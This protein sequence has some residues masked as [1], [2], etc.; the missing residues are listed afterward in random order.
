[1]KSN[2]FYIFEYNSKESVKKY[3]RILMM[4]FQIPLLLFILFMIF[5]P[6]V[7]DVLKKKPLPYNNPWLFL[8]IYPVLIGISGIIS[9]IVHELG[10]VF[11]GIITGKSFYD[12]TFLVFTIE[13]SK[14]T[15]KFHFYYDDSYLK[16]FVAVGKATMVDK[17]NKYNPFNNIIYYLGGA[18]F[19]ILAW[20]LLFIFQG[21]SILSLMML[22]SGLS[23]LIPFRYISTTGGFDGYLIIS[24]LFSPKAR[25]MYKMQHEV[26][27][28]LFA[29]VKLTADE[30][31]KISEYLIHSP[32]LNNQCLAYFLLAEFYL[33]NRCFEKATY[34][35]DEI[36]EMKK[37][38][39]KGEAFWYN[40]D[41]IKRLEDNILHDKSA[42]E[43]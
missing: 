12:M 25:E 19:N 11:F 31:F 16:D 24:T 3:N 32:Y 1:M 37:I 21:N 39:L 33:D 2:E 15:K 22:Y 17:N 13:Y 9:T 20:I 10:H 42:F 27:K 41:E 40:E 7:V 35:V 6:I 28:Y 8:I 23:A 5:Y 26:A 38:L 18:I 34:Y 14:Q 30:I 29:G 43:Q 4:L 36:K